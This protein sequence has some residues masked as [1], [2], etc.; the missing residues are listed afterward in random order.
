MFPGHDP[1]NPYYPV[2]PSLPPSQQVPNASPLTIGLPHL[3]ELLLAEYRTYLA[4]EIQRRRG[5]G[6][7]TLDVEQ[8][9]AAAPCKNFYDFC[10]A[11]LAE[12]R[13]VENFYVDRNHGLLLSNNA[14]VTVCPQ[15]NV[16]GTMQESGAVGVTQGLSQPH[17]G[18]V[19][20]SSGDVPII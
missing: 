3:L 10:V 15:T 14:R 11:Y 13:P 7:R 9:L 2:G 20:R 18:G 4:T 12:N 6:Q 8:A 16:Q 17:L 19:V 1:Q 5:Q